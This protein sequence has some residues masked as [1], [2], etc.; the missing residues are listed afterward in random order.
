MDKQDSSLGSRNVFLF[1]SETRIPT[2]R[3]SRNIKNVP[4]GFRRNPNRN[5][6]H[7]PGSCPPKIGM[8]I[9]MRS[10]GWCCESDQRDWSKWH[11]LQI[12]DHGCVFIVSWI[13]PFFANFCLIFTTPTTLIWPPLVGR[14]RQRQW[15]QIA[16]NHHCD[17]DRWWRAMHWRTV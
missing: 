7:A 12:D 14:R 2:R 6:N 10:L 17:V 13:L 15:D 16:I 3:K 9:G 4:L 5:R 1:L 8:K 11:G